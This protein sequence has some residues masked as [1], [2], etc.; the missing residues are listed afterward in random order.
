MKTGFD[1]YMEEK[2]RDPEFAKNFNKEYAEIAKLYHAMRDEATQELRV[3]CISSSY[4]SE[5]TLDYLDE[6]HKQ[7]TV[8]VPFYISKGRQGEN[9]KDDYYMWFDTGEYWEFDIPADLRSVFDF[10]ALKEYEYLR[11]SPFHKTYDSL[12]QALGIKREAK[13]A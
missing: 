6:C 10:A 13:D 11:I 9:F 1:K 4:L 12:D 7:G 5:S 2:T 8:M 3:L